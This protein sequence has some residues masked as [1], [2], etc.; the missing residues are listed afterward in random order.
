MLIQ[1]PPSQTR[2]TGPYKS[3]LETKAE[4]KRTEEKLH[5]LSPVIKASKRAVDRTLGLYQHGQ[6]PKAGSMSQPWPPPMVNNHWDREFSPKDFPTSH[7]VPSTLPKRWEQYDNSPVMLKPP[8]STVVEQVLDSEITKC[9]SW[10][11][12]FAARASLSEWNVWKDYF[13][14]FVTKVLMKHMIILCEELC[15]LCLKANG[16]WPWYRLPEKRL[17][18]YGRSNNPVV[19]RRCWSLK[20]SNKYDNTERIMHTCTQNIHSLFV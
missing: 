3:N 4:L 10:F 6:Q 11:E 8:T 19:R 18:G 17:K 14:W 20:F 2:S 9:S 7:K 16:R 5:I 12:A 13:S 1:L 15:H